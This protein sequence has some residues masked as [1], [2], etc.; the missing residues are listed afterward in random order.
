MNEQ[1]I[2]MQFHSPLS[3]LMEKFIREKQACGC[4]YQRES[5]ELLRLDRFL[6]RIGLQS[7]ELPGNV[8]DRW[9]AKQIYEKPSN[10]KLRIIRI[11]QFALYLLRQGIEA[12]VPETTKACIKRM[13]FTPFFLGHRTFVW[14]TPICCGHAFMTWNAPGLLFG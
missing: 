12:Y 11:R 1:N 9:T 5:H 8:V 14:V 10:Q 7:P 3:G 2:K 4:R 13:D 6:C